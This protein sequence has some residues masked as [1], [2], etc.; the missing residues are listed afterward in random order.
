MK[1]FPVPEAFEMYGS[2]IKVKRVPDSGM[3]SNTEYA[4]WN[5]LDQTIEIRYG[6]TPDQARHSFLHEW[7]H[8]AFEAAGYPKLSTDEV[9]VDTMAGLLAQMLKT[10]K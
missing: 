7:F 4:N 1:R 10:A 6:I 3:Q 9:L 8:A 2:T 5:A